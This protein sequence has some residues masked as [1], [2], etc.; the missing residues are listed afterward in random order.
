MNTNRIQYL[1]R[2]DPLMLDHH[3]NLNPAYRQMMN[4]N[5]W[6]IYVKSYFNRKGMLNCKEWLFPHW[7]LGFST[8][9]KKLSKKWNF[10]AW[11]LPFWTKVKLMTCFHE[12]SEYESTNF[13]YYVPYTYYVIFVL[14]FW[15][16]K[17]PLLRMKNL[18][19]FWSEKYWWKNS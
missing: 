19:S 5:W 12:F 16:K 4:L 1:F 6:K 15:E 14:I 11:F 13:L 10:Y 2:V 9:R 17:C 18:L 8:K 3:L 7:D